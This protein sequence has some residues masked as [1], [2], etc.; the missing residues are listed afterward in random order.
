[1][2]R[3]EIISIDFAKAGQ[4]ERIESIP[5]VAKL[6]VNGTLFPDALDIHEFLR[7]LKVSG[8]SPLFTCAA[9]GKFCCSGYYVGIEHTEAHYILHNTYDCSDADEIIDTFKYEIPWWQIEQ[10]L[11]SLSKAVE[12]LPKQNRYLEKYTSHWIPEFE[13]AQ[14]TLQRRLN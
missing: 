3:L 6:S 12:T 11:Q 13:E 9:C 10:V 2:D 7:T 14:L 4:V 5:I 1:M 8:I